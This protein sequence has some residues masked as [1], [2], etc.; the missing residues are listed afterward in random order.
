[1]N[2]HPDRIAGRADGMA[3][4]LAAL[5]VLAA[6]R[7]LFVLRGRRA[8]LTAALVTGVASADDVRDCVEL[9]PGIDP[10]CFGTVP[11]PLARAGI[12]ASAGFVLTCR[13]TAHARP[14]TVWRLLNRA[15]AEQWLA[16][17]PDRPDPNDPPASQG[18]LFPISPN[19]PTPAGA[20]AGAGME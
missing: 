6:G 9:P 18:V 12:I 2:A 13:P 16:D 14:V 19:E 3:R 1:M 15:A 17:H 10:K 7:E 8:L 5:D 4:K 20:T 11:G